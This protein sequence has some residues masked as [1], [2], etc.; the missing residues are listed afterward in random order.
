MP[1]AT[2]E[3]AAIFRV[4][5][6]GAGP[7]D[8]TWSAKVEEL[9]ALCESGGSST[10]I[11]FLVTAMLARSVSGDAD[12]YAIKPKHAKNNENAYSAR[13]LCHSVIVPLAAELGVNIG[14]S[15][16]EP[17]NNQ[18]Y[19]RMTYLGDGTPVRE[20]ARPAFNYMVGL[21]DQLKHSTPTEAR[22][23]LRAFIAVRRRYH[24]VYATNVGALTVSWAT[25]AGAIT[26][27]VGENSEGGRR[28][29]AVVAALF[30]VFAGQEFVDSGRINDPS[31]HYPGDV[32]V[33]SHDGG[34]EKAVEVRDK[35]VAESD[36]YIFGRNCLA[37]GAVEAAIVLAAAN[38][39]RLNDA[40][41]ASW[42]SRTGLGLSL[43]YGWDFFVEQALFWAS[44][45]RT[46]TVAL[47]V[48]RIEARLIT[49]EASSAAVD[50][51]HELTR[52]PETRE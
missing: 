41:I 45:P 3:A 42:A 12:L 19:F 38:Q 16:R 47:A 27:L 49:V 33:R 8:P 50:L 28:A 11:A 9:S 36:V 18:P 31:R 6:D 22:T 13:S 32:A 46:E 39:P 14:V 23:A 51:W 20:S 26:R 35:P 25:L 15:G 21:I 7:V 24:L 2:R 4:A 37:K 30:D 40:A 34:W 48:E 17:L 10:H 43:F 52:A 44:A 29:Q 1:I 5:A